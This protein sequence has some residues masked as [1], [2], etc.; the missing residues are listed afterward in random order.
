MRGQFAARTRPSS[1][2]GRLNKLNSLKLGCEYHLYW[3]LGFN[4]RTERLA[5]RGKQTSLEASS[6]SESWRDLTL[7]KRIWYSESG[8]RQRQL[9]LDGG[10]G[11]VTIATLVIMSRGSGGSCV[12][13]FDGDVSCCGFG[14]GSVRRSRG[15]GGVQR[16]KAR[17][18]QQTARGDGSDRGAVV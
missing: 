6:L 10:G 5:R 13:A 3:L 8:L 9:L 17:G 11:P 1:G 15:G 18:A 4:P 14:G 7:C 2:G 12:V 16:R